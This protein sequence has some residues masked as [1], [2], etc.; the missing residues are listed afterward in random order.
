M[1]QT[2]ESPADVPTSDRAFE[3]VHLGGR[4]SLE[5]GP[6]HIG[7]QDF[8]GFQPVGPLLTRIAAAAIERAKR[9]GAA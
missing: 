5:D 2:C 6:S 7:L 1:T 8:G 4:D 9:R 3:N